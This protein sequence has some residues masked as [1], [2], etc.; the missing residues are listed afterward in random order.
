MIEL[1]SLA[2]QFGD[3]VAVRS[4]SLSVPR[5][6]IFG[7][8]GPDGAGK[9]T[10]F[11]MLAGILEPSAGTARIDG[12]DIRAAA[13]EVKARLGYMPQAFSLYDDL[14]VLENLHFTAEIYGVAREALASRIERL[15]GFSRLGAF[16]DRL[17][18]ALSGGMRQKL[19]LAATLIHEPDVLLLDEPTTGVDPISRREFWQILHELNR[20]GKTVIV[21]TPYMDEAERCARLAL[22]HEGRILTVNTPAALRARMPGV[23]F[24]LFASPRRDALAALRGLAEVLQASLFGEA[25]HLVM[26]D[27]A[28]GERVRHHLTGAGISVRSM[29]QIDP[30]LE[31]IFVSLLSTRAA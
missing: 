26:A 23:V 29:Q 28:A 31:D 6:E 10:L 20:E 14:T 25:V 3:I 21:A 16:G 1:D 24:E 13:D 17:A 7:L 9:T 27:A 11:R 12:L 15:L 19:A 4:V 5:G 8:L 30:S 18:A 22:M 2:K